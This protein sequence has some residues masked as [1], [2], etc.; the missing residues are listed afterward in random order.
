VLVTDSAAVDGGIAKVV[1]TS[2]RG[3][4]ERGYETIVFTASPDHALHGVP[5]LSV[6]TTGQGPF[7]GDKNVAGAALRGIYNVRARTMLRE[8]LAASDAE[9]TIVH[10]HSWTK[11]LSASVFDA[12]VASRVPQSVTLH[13]YFMACPTGS[14]YL[15]GDRDICTIAPMSRRCIAKNCDSRS[16]AYKAYRVARQFVQRDLV[17]VP[18][19]ARNMVTVSEFSA[20][21]LRGVLPPGT[22]I[23][24]VENPVDVVREP[25]VH[26]EFNRPFVYLGR[27]SAEKGVTLFAAAAKRAGVDAVFVGE[28]EERENILKAN[29]HARITGWIPSE[30][31]V[32]QLRLA[33]TVV[34]PSLWYE[35]LGLVVV[36][37]AAVG[38]PAIV[39]SGTAPQDYVADGRTGSYFRRGDAADLARALIAHNDDARVAAMSEAAYERYWS[40]PLSIDAHLEALLRHYEQARSA[41]TTSR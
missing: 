38:V 28:G 9:R 6:V 4:A 29:P 23:G 15:H 25:R 24:V 40:R 22:P 20:A 17:R 39:P 35:T 37:A 32:E 2:A 31:V 7:L 10:V 36:E 11:A 26:A 13:E 33:R 8:V 5:G 16:Y 34:L 1:A 30:R 21:V 41:Q 19:R 12:I 27:L 18:A 14:L 3:L